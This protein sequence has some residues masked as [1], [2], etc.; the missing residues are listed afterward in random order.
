M[1]TPNQGCV[2]S[3]L[4]RPVD[5]GAARCAGVRVSVCRPQPRP[6]DRDA[7]APA[8]GVRPGGV[9]RRTSPPRFH[10]GGA[11]R[12][13][14]T[15]VSVPTL[16]FVQEVEWSEHRVPVVLF[17]AWVRSPFHGFAY[18]FLPEPQLAPDRNGNGSQAGLG[19][20]LG[21]GGVSRGMRHRS[22][23][24]V[25]RGGGT[26]S[27]HRWGLACT[28]APASVEPAG[29]LR[30]RPSASP[31]SAEGMKPVPDLMTAALGGRPTDP[32]PPQR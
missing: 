31:V 18:A 23:E 8:M 14:Q 9:S 2:N 4:M 17:A 6:R 10:R 32:P 20:G 21:L 22:S 11:P 13:A 3:Q 24:I 30:T 7:H 12:R 29:E 5:R 16:Q 25:C 1:N 27:A 19:Q 28:H 15:G 26:C